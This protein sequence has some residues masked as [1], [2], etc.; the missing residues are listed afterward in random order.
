MK[1]KLYAIVDLKLPGSTRHSDKIIEIAIVLHDGAQ[2]I[3]TYSS[4][5]SPGVTC[6]WHRSTH[7]HH[8]GHGAGR[9]VLRW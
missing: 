8:A 1:Q 9:P 2:I 4:L 7:R 6:L 3:D 5:I